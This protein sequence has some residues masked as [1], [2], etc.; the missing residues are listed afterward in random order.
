MTSADKSL[1]IIARRAT[2]QSTIGERREAR[3]YIHRRAVELTL[4]TRNSPWPTFDR[5][6]CALHILRLINFTGAPSPTNAFAFS[7]ESIVRHDDEE[8]ARK[9]ISFSWRIAHLVRVPAY[10]TGTPGLYRTLAVPVAQSRRL[11]ARRLRR[12]AAIY[13]TRRASG[14]Y[15]R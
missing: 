8:A 4:Y 10:I 13:A 14:H 3:I 7:S 11:A 6:R 15:S 2:L 5:G 9:V 12:H 1:L